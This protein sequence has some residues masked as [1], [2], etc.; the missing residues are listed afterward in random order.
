LSDCKL[1]VDNKEFFVSKAILSSRSS[2]F[3]AMFMNDMKEKIQN[4]AVIQDIKS[5]VFGQFLKF[6][7]FVYLGNF[8]KIK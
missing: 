7:K 3:K 8:D 6:L 4:Q 5:E 2:V 1:I